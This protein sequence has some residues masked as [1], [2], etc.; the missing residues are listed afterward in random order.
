MANDVGY[1]FLCLLAIC[2][3]SQE[4][5]LPFHSANGVISSPKGLNLDEVAF[6]FIG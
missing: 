6:I 5:P 2:L 3:S 4:D 1:L